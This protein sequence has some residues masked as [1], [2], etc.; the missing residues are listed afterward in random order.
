[1]RKYLSACFTIHF[2]NRLMFI[3]IWHNLYI[4][5]C[6]HIAQRLQ[7]WAHNQVVMR[8]TQSRCV[9]SLKQQCRSGSKFYCNPVITK[10]AD[11]TFT[12]LPIF[13]QQ[14]S[15]TWCMNM[16]CNCLKHSPAFLHYSDELLKVAT[17]QPE[18][19][20]FKSHCLTLQASVFYYN[21]RLTK[22]LWVDSVNGSW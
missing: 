20:G 15:S 7:H 9:S 8:S 2:R 13:K 5:T 18:S 6:I 16:Y 3:H 1:M 22:A 14:Q 19:S 4:H 10:T 11:I 17:S 12:F 21:P